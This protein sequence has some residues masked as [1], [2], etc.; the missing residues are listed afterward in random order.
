MVSIPRDLDRKVLESLL[1]RLR[2]ADAVAARIE[3]VSGEWVGRPYRECPLGGGVGE[4][5]VFS[6]SIDAFDCVTYVECVLAA[7]VSDSTRQFLDI[8][9]A[10]R[11]RNGIVTWE[12]RNHYMTGWIRENERAG[13][14]R[15]RTRGAAVVRRE[16]RL[17]VVPGI[18]E[19]NVR[20]ASIPK[21]V[22]SGRME[23]VVTGD[24][25][26]FASTRPNLDVFHCGVLIRKGA[27][28]RMRHAARSRG[29][30]VE[31]DFGAFLSANRMVGVILVRPEEA[32]P[33]A[34]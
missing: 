31:Q 27:G 30:V 13:F 32:F 34:A 4:R 18:G 6:A 16:R 26:F 21:R 28:V 3:R 11:Y 29:R 24:L 2:D 10:I 12:T 33:R 15:D 25:A 1:G 22:F 17:A 8:L 5:E 7:A 19:R 9:R 14:L 23:R 20:V